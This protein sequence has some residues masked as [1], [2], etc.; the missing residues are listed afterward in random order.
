MFPISSQL[1]WALRE[2]NKQIVANINPEPVIDHLFQDGVITL[3]DYDFLTERHLSRTD[4]MRR[5]MTRLHIGGNPT[6]F[7]TLLN[8]LKKDYPCHVK[9]VDQLCLQTGIFNLLL[10]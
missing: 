10:V 6:A 1:K 5:L 8:A 4:R 2:I 3:A 7:V 9:K